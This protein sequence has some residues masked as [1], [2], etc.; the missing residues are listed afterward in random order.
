MSGGNGPGFLRAHEAIYEW[1]YWARVPSGPRKWCTG[2]VELSRRHNMMR[3]IDDSGLPV[4]FSRS[5]RG[6]A[7][8]RGSALSERQ[9]VMV[10]GAWVHGRM[11]S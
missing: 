4:W 2:R 3:C 7:C 11:V 6:T 5:M 1:G 8:T 10:P 9:V